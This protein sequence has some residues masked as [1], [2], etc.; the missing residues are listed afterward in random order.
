MSKKPVKSFGLVSSS[1]PGESAVDMPVRDAVV[2]LP[3]PWALH[4]GDE[5]TNAHLAYRVVGPEEA[6]VI[7][8]LGGI[9]AHRNVCGADGWWPDMAGEGHGVDTRKFRVLG[10]DYLAGRGE[11]SAPR[12]DGK[13]PP[14]Y[15]DI[16]ERKRSEELKLLA[17]PSDARSRRGAG[18]HRQGSSRRHRPA[19]RPSQHRLGTTETILRQIAVC[20]DFHLIPWSGLPAKSPRMCT[21]SLVA[22]IPPRSSC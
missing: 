12:P 1:S 2:Q 21:T 7:A 3:N 19:P 13:F 22:C 17:E 20:A 8:V 10:I 14:L 18:A 5:L 6:P 15:Q 11:S 9:S 4:H 16:S